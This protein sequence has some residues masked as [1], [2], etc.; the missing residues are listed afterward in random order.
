[1]ANNKKIA[2]RI[3]GVKNLMEMYFNSFKLA[4]RFNELLVE[5]DAMRQFDPPSY[6]I[7][8]EYLELLEE[9]YSQ[10]GKK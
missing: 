6:E 3:E 8:E 7:K 5:H 1:V 4:D 10:G 2:N 9:R